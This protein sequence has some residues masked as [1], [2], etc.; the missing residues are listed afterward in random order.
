MK[1]RIILFMH[2]SADGYIAG[3]EDDLDWVAH[4]DDV[5]NELNELI[6]S[7]DS[8]LFGR[9]T[10]EGFQSYWPSVETAPDS[11]PSERAFSRWLDQ[12]RKLVLSTSM[13]RATWGNSHI[14]ASLDEAVA[15]VQGEPGRH[16]AVFGS[17][18]AARALAERGLID[19]FRIL[20]QPAF[21]GK[22]KP[23]FDASALRRRLRL[24]SA[25]PLPS[26]VV[27]L[28]YVASEAS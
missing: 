15:A 14:V 5:W 28:R 20:L 25:R 7:C 22:G 1:R 26:G 19:E 3:P 21:V 6:A 16:V 2:V 11:G 23:L 18:R 12:A 13:Q 4:G 24:E 9:A 17:A 10:Y 27:S 8:A